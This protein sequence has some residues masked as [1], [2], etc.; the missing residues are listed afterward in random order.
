MITRD[1]IEAVLNRVR[2][3]LQADGGNI[4]LYYR[5]NVLPVALPPLRERREDI[6]DLME[7]FLRRYFRRNGEDEPPISDAVRQAF[8]RYSW[9]GNV[10][11]LENTCERIAQTCTCGTVRIGCVAPT[12][13][14]GRAHRPGT[15]QFHRRRCRRSRGQ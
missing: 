14:S 4:E 15:W 5:L 7:H 9:P 1:R 3:F 8:M 10:R 11:E 12:S 13:C 6:P 2:P